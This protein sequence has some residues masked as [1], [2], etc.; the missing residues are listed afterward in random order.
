MEN[1]N[2]AEVEQKIQDAATE[3]A[4][5][6]FKTVLG[7][8]DSIPCGFAWVTCK[9]QFKGNTRQG[10]KEREILKALG[11]TIEY[12]RTFG[13]WMPGRQNVQNVDVHLEG[14]K[15]ACKVIRDTNFFL[16]GIL[17]SMDVYPHSR[18]D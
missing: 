5:N 8:R 9:P 4:Q 17:Y 15:A 6:Y 16:D 7:G 12:D 11:F 13:L 10:R 18:L 3:A 1:T 2:L 14:A